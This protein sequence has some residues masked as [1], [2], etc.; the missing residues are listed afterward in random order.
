MTKKKVGPQITQVIAV[1]RK[2]GVVI[3]RAMGVYFKCWFEGD[4]LCNNTERDSQIYDP[5][6]HV[7]PKWVRNRVF[8]QASAILKGKD[9]KTPR[10]Q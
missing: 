4:R 7:L 1:D 10:A 9:N 6:E 2:R 5:H 3:I 8:R